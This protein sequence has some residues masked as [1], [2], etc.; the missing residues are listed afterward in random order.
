MAKMRE[1]RLDRAEQKRLEEFFVASSTARIA[2]A[3]VGVNET[4]ASYYFN[5]LRGLVFQKTEKL[6]QEYV[7][8]SY[9][10]LIGAV[11]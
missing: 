9:L 10:N 4:T 1:S 8:E 11:M 7:D 5:C 2:A 3:M 6:A